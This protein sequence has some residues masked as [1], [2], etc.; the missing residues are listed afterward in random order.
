MVVGDIIFY[1]ILGTPMLLVSS[2]EIAQD[3]ME[4]RTSTTSDRPPM[5]I[6]DL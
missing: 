1:Q 6:L 2:A 3:L 5:A 4:K